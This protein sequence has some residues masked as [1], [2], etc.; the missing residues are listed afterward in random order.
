M[1]GLAEERRYEAL[2]DVTTHADEGD[3]TGEQ[4][5]TGTSEWAVEK[6]CFGDRGNVARNYSVLQSDALHSLVKEKNV[7][8]NIR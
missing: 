1:H 8:R 6:N 7:M 2:G 5:T 3:G 4:T